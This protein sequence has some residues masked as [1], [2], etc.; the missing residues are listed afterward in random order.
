MIVQVSHRPYLP[1]TDYT[2]FYAQ[3]VGLLHFPL[4]EFFEVVSSYF[5]IPPYQLTPNSFQF[6]CGVVVFCFYH[7]PFSPT[8]FH[9][10]FT[11]RRVK[12]GFSTLLPDL[13]PSSCNNT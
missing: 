10:F 13:P 3:M 1:P 8:V 2:T 7:V 11:I 9:Y 12:L 6:F 4:P 5:R